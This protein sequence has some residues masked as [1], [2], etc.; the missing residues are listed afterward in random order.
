MIRELEAQLLAEKETVIRLQSSF[1]FEK[2]KRI[3]VEESLRELKKIHETLA[4]NCEMS[5]EYIVNKVTI[6]LFYFIIKAV[7][8]FLRKILR[9]N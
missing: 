4:C 6:S 2:E 8:C 3:K 9:M 1:N 5:E 7:G